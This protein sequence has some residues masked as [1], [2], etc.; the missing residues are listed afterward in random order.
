VN[1]DSHR[2]RTIF[3]EDA[4]TYQRSRPVAPAELFDDLVAL[5]GLRAC[6]QVLEIGCGTGQATLPMSRRGLAVTAVE[7]GP[8]L[9]AVARRTVQ[10]FPQTRIVTG[11]FE[12]WSVPAEPFAAVVAFNMVHWIDPAVRYA[13][14]A[15]VLR[16]GGFLVLGSVHVVRPADADKFWWDVQE[17]YEAVGWEGNPAT[18]DSIGT[19]HLPAEADPYFEEVAARRYLFHHRIPARDHL[20]NMAIQSGTRRL[21]PD[22]SA[23][24]LARVG[25][26]LESLG[27]PELT[28]HFVGQ[29]VIARLRS[30]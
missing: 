13:K 29:L 5:T 8:A 30:S 20:A 1:D 7:L 16:P 22:R 26:R 23:E 2:L 3:N 24:L 14:P 11:S 18:P 17:D 12:D 6:D 25:R 27:W 15:D 19:G 9:A 4:E 10:D 28:I 21:G